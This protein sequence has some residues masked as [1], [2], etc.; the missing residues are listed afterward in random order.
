ML[1]PPSSLSSPPPIL[2]PLNSNST[3]LAPPVHEDWPFEILDLDSFHD[4]PVEGVLE[5]HSHPHAVVHILP[6]DMLSVDD[7]LASQCLAFCQLL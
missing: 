5:V 2:H 1:A 3:H 6:A 7:S 4:L